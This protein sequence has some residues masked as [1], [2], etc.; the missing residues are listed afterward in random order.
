MILSSLPVERRNT[1]SDQECGRETFTLALHVEWLIEDGE[2][3]DYA[4]AARALGL[5][6][7]R[8]T[9]VMN[10][11]L[12]APKIQSGSWLATFARVS[13]RRGARY[14]SRYASGRVR[15]CRR[16]DR[17]PRPWLSTYVLSRDPAAKIKT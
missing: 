9:Q 15:S 17:E 7:A 2:L 5:T 13:G 8:L 16:R 11:L 12:L 1:S 14:G 6:R 3:E 10:L 4:D